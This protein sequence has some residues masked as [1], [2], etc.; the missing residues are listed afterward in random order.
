MM[1]L[2]RLRVVRLLAAIAVVA[3]VCAA[4]ARADCMTGSSQEDGED[5][6]MLLFAG[7]GGVAGA[8]VGA[9]VGYGAWAASGAGLEN[10]EWFLQP[11]LI[12]GAVGGMVGGIYLHVVLDEAERRRDRDAHGE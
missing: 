12:L 3:V 1:G 4:P 11:G 6:N 5:F 10:Q 7:L 8:G 2:V 9:A